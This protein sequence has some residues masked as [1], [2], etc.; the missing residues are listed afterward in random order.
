MTTNKIE[1]YDATL[2]DGM[3]GEGMSLTAA[4]KVRVVHKLDALGIDLIEAGFPASNPKE[5]ELF[6]LLAAEKLQHA[7]IVAFGMTRR[8]DIAA[9][10]D[11]ALQILAGCFAPVCTIVGK[12]WRLHLEKVVRVSAEE[13]L[14]LIRDSVA[15]LAAAGKRV[16]YDAEHFFDGY[17]DDPEYSVAC[18]RAAAVAGAE[19]VVLCDTNGSSLPGQI[20]AAVRAVRAQLGEEVA[21]GIHCHNDLELGVANTLAAVVEGA[22]QVQGTM[23]GIGERTGNANLV[24]IIANLELR[25]GYELIG[26]D[27]LANLTE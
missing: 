1:T 3:Q 5:L 9:A 27:R 24:T 19:R 17:R 11:P 8:R 16:I 2:R 21:L 14:E 26:A 13:N 7:Q 4:E 23:N 6:G 12:T 10:D 25:L 20:A 22:T 18:L 15:Y